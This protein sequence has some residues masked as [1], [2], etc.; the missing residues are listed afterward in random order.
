[1]NSSFT[2]GAAIVIESHCTDGHH[3]RWDSNPY[4]GGKPAA[5]VLLSAGILFAGCS[6]TSALRLLRHIR[7]QVFD[8][9]TY[10][11]YQAGYLFPAIRMVSWT[12]LIITVYVS[13]CMRSVVDYIPDNNHHHWCTTGTTGAKQSRQAGE[14]QR[15]W[16][17]VMLMLWR[18]NPIWKTHQWSCIKGIIKA[19]FLLLRQTLNSAI[20]CTKCIYA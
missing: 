4:I 1:M 10:Y 19:S 12:C 3:E 7:I 6:A 14:M 17:T 8:D 11:N 2:N 13:Y 9:R 5:N 15:M 16:F 20:F 18:Y